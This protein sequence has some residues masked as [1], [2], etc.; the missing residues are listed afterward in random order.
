[1]ALIAAKWSSGPLP[2][3][4]QV[5]STHDIAVEYSRVQLLVLC[6]FHSQGI[7]QELREEL[8]LASRVPGQWA[9]TMWTLQYVTWLQRPGFY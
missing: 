9:G 1:M 3:S 6:G 2:V 4:R 8:L 7:E 5:T